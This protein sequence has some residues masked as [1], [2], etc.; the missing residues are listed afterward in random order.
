VPQIAEIKIG[1]SS[2]G[3]FYRIHSFATRTWAISLATTTQPYFRAFAS[4]RFTHAFTI[5]A[6]SA[7]G[8]GLSSGKR[9]VPFVTR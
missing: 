7:L 6:I 3:G 1:F 5:F 8:S 4:F 9:I 2:E